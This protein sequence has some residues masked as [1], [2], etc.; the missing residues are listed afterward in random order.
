MRRRQHCRSWL[1]GILLLSASL[2]ADDRPRIAII[3]DD[4]GNE[5]RAGVRAIQLDGPIAYAI[6]PGTPRARELAELAHAAGRDVLLHLPLQ[7]E[8]DLEAR[9]PG[10]LNLDMSRQAFRLAVARSLEAVPHVTGINT[11]RGSLLTRH[12]GHMGWLM[13][14]LGRRGGLFFVD[15]YTTADSVALRIARERGI[16]SVRRDVFLDPDRRLDTVER[17]FG[18]LKSIA[19]TRGYAVGIGHPYPETLD[20]LARELPSL[21]AEGFALVPIS[22]LVSQLDPPG[23]EPRI[24]SG[25]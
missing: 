21:D 22:E 3:I 6:L 17:E 1:L 16:P 5:R 14:D 23:S 11:H 12:P 8:A 10:G 4:L 18:R 20:F 19:E 15:S 25:E 7:A 2:L 24:A 13:D 9:E